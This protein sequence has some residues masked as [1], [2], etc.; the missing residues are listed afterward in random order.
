MTCRVP[1]S[2][3]AVVVLSSALAGTASLCAASGEPVTIELHARVEA[4][5]NVL[6]VGD[7]AELKGGSAAARRALAKLDVAEV[8]PSRTQEISRRLV[9]VRLR[10]SDIDSSLYRVTGRDKV[11][12]LPPGREVLESVDG[13]VTASIQRAYAERLSVSDREIKVTLTQPVGDLG[14]ANSRDGVTTRPFLPSSLAFG[15]VRLRLGVYL[16]SRLVST[17]S[18]SVS[19]HRLRPI[20]VAT[21]DIPQGEIIQASH[22]EVT[23]QP[24]V[25]STPDALPEQLIGRTARRSI[26]IGQQV[27]IRDVSSVTRRKVEPY[28]IK[29]RDRVRIVAR[30]GTL[31]VVANAGEAMQNGRKGDTIRVR[32]SNSRRLISAKVI[33]STEVQVSF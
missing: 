2:V 17:V 14:V 8:Q 7:L 23:H 9:E 20:A 11:T 26:G 25:R 27:G 16:Q 10:L 5:G 6:H 30:K 29:S 28:L 24:T 4:P 18:A 33:S 3:A 22:I 1:F 31:T 15:N 12:I 13:M 19:V 32:N 21:Q